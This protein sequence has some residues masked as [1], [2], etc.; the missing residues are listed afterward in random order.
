VA[1][2][3][4]ERFLEDSHGDG[5]WLAKIGVNS[6]CLLALSRALCGRD[7]HGARL[8]MLNIEVDVC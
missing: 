5:I 4:L 7:V 2:K 1:F 8:N 6:Q 3:A